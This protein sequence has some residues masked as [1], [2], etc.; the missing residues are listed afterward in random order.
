MLD[1]SGRG[2]HATQ[3]TN[4]KRPTLRARYNLLTYSEQFDNAA[5][6]ASLSNVSVTPNT[7]VAPNGTMTADSLVFSPTAGYIYQTQ[8]VGNVS[9]RTFT[10]SCWLWTLS[11]TAKVVLRL[12]DASATTINNT[13]CDLTTTPTRFTLTQTFTS[14]DTQLYFGID[15]RSTGVGGD[16][17]AGTVI[18]WGADLRPASQ[19]TGLVGPTYQ[20]IAAATDYDATGFLPYLQFDGVDDA[21]V[22]NSI[23]PGAVDKAQVFAGVRRLS[24]AASQM[25]AETSTNAAG[26]G[27]FYL[28]I[29]GSANYNVSSSGTGNNVLGFSGFTSPTTTV[30]SLALTTLAANSAAAV[31]G[32]FNGVPAVGTNVNSTNSTGN[33][34]T[35]P[36]FVGQRNEATLPLNGLVYSL[37]GRFGPIL[38]AGQISATETWVNSKTGAY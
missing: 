4:S 17:L 25:V 28:F 26:G 9:G 32:R 14:S 36:L 16:G 15:R 24:D 23:D 19:A 22:T 38:T 18:A 37:I 27:A 11:G 1:K 10:Y 8:T 6:S 2:N 31:S 3:A 33:F 20:R 7:T 30:I 12:Y 21:M 5:W 35:F 29:P 13:V 34:G